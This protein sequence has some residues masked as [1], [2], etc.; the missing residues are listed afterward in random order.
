MGNVQYAAILNIATGTN[1]NLVHVAANRDQRPDTDIIFHND[2]TDDDTT[3]ID[4]NA[5]AGLREEMFIRA[6][7]GSHHVLLYA[8]FIAA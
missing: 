1:A 5:L 7:G 8:E 6:K 3:W 2:V 4:H